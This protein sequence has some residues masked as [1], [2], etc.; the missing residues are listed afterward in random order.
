MLQFIKGKGFL[1]QDVRV[2]AQTGNLEKWP[3]ER[4]ADGKIAE[5]VER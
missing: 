5:A 2:A 3:R 4:E 1:S